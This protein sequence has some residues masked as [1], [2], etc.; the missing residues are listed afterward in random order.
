VFEDTV[1]RKISEPKKDKIIGGWKK[2]PAEELLN[3]YSSPNKIRMMNS[4]R[5]RLA[6]HVAHV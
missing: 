2:L 6:R 3:F 5:M 4:R 1:L